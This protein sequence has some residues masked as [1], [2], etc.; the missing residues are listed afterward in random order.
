M[1]AEL[2]LNLNGGS[3]VPDGLADAPAPAALKADAKK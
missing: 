1:I 3:L 2:G